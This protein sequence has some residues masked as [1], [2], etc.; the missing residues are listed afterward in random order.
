MI[1]PDDAPFLLKYFEPTFEAQDIIQQASR[2]FIITMMING[3]K[4]PAFSAK[5]L[6]LPQPTADTVNQIVELSRQR[7]ALDRAVVEKGIRESIEN[8]SLPSANNQQPSL[9]PPQQVARPKAQAQLN[10][11]AKNPSKIASTLIKA[12]T[13]GASGTTPES[14]TM[15]IQTTPET[16][17]EPKKRKR[18]RRGGKKNKKRTPTEENIQ[19][20]P[21]IAAPKTHQQQTAN[22]APRVNKTL[23]DEQV[24]RLR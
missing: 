5:T 4:A 21:H 15:Q 11:I 6:N 1:S 12:V 10:K 3:E 7:Y 2:H 20:Q 24:I 18:T 8:K 16:T 19:Q 14:A 17:E 22:P 13:G 23:E 9:P